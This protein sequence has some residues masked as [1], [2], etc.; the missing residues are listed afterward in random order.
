MFCLGSIFLY[1]EIRKNNFFFFPLELNNF[2]KDIKKTDFL[3][4]KAYCWVVRQTTGSV[5]TQFA[6]RE[7]KNPSLPLRGVLEFSNAKWIDWVPHWAYMSIAFF[8]THVTYAFVKFMNLNQMHRVK[9]WHM[10]T[11]AQLVWV[12]D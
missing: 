10:N 11:K 5:L 9:I 2:S 4:N 8:S 12:K 6:Q 1:L 3:I 7:F